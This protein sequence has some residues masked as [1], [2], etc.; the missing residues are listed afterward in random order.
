[1]PYDQPYR[2]WT[3]EQKKK[4][5]QTTRAWQLANPQKW[6]AIVKKSHIKRGIIKNSPWRFWLPVVTRRKAV[7]ACGDACW[8][9][10]YGVDWRA[11][12][13]DH[14][15]GG[16]NA[17]RRKRKTIPWNQVLWRVWAGEMQL[18]CANCNFI[19]GLEEAERLRHQSTTVL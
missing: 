11:L 8:A 15:N 14:V 12:H 9:C 7:W 10:G 1:M 3:P 2:E 18:L 19:K 6:K 13:F 4:H 16:G 17:E 5:Y